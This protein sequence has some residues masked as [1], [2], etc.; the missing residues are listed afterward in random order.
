MKPSKSK[1]ALAKVINEN[2]GWREGIFA[3]QDRSRAVTFFMGK[4]WRCGN[5]WEDDAFECV[6]GFISTEVIKN[7]HQ[8]ILSLEEYYQAYPKADDGWIEWKGGECPVDGSAEV[9]YRMADDDP[10]Y[11]NHGIAGELRWSKI[12]SSGDIIT[13]RLHKPDVKPEF[14]ESVTRSIPDPELDDAGSRLAKALE[15]VKSAAPH[16]LS[17]KY[18]FDGNEVMGERK[19]TIE[20]L[21]QDYRNAKGHADRLQKEAGEAAVKAESF[22]VEIR[23]KILE[24]QELIGISKQELEPELVITNW[25]DLKVGDEVEY[26]Q[27]GIR[28]LLGR[29]GVVT[30]FDPFDSEQNVML[31]FDCY[32]SRDTGWPRKWRFIR[33]P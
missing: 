27:G 15:L 11:F 7:W 3:A 13:Y 29:V 21:A 28:H 12:G 32:T 2:G 24:L 8:T 17:D 26:A 33:R 25:R 4:P 23:K 31:S 5:A 22:A 30:G 6:G 9:D 20:Q 10:D 1:L 14:C 16:M 19:P 18:K